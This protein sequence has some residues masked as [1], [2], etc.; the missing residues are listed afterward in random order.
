MLISKLVDTNGDG[1]PNA[2]DQVVMGYYPLH[3]SPAPEDFGEWG[4]K[5]GTVASATMPNS[6]N[7][8]AQTS[9]GSHSWQESGSWEGYA[10]SGSTDF[11]ELSDKGPPGDGTDDLRVKTGSTSLPPDDFA[12]TQTQSPSTD[13]RFID[14]NLFY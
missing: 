6:D 14:V 9:L 7:V 13:D 2:G 4:R 10:E 8:V 12:F 5:T 11:S 3:F 1:V